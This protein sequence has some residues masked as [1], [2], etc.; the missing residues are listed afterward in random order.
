M[1][2][3]KIAEKWK[4]WDKEDQAEKSEEEAKKLISQK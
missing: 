4:I 2:V 3:K 1:K